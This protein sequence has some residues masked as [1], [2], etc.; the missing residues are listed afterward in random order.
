MLNNWILCRETALKKIR[1][2]KKVKVEDSNLF[3]DCVKNSIKN[4]KNWNTDS[5]YQTTKIK[6]LLKDVKKF[7]YFV[8]NNFDFKTDYQFN[9]INIG[10]FE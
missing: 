5:I 6:Y 8:E 10:F 2:I 9:K 1:E 4:K 3:K 7:I